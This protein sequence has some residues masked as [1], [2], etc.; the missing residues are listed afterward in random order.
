MKKL[1]FFM[2]KNKP[3][4]IDTSVINDAL[5]ETH[6]IIGLIEDGNS[7]YPQILGKPI[8]NMVRVQWDARGL[9]LL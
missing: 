6:E 2:T 9:P 1:L 8:R 4:E 5:G 3:S 7:L